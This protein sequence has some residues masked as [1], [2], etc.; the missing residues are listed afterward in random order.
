MVKQIRQIHSFVSLANS[1]YGISVW[2]LTSIRTI[3]NTTP[4]VF[5]DCVPDK[6]AV[7]RDLLESVKARKLSYFGEADNARNNTK[8]SHKS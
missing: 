4:A 8:I 2:T 3:E 7:S 6:A 5:L 1:S